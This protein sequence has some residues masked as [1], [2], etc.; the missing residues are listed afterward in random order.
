MHKVLHALEAEFHRTCT[1]ATQTITMTSSG[2][3]T[4]LAP[5]RPECC[6][7][8]TE[9]IFVTLLD[10]SLSNVM[11]RSSDRNLAFVRR[12]RPMVWFISLG[13]GFAP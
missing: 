13:D 10:A 7:N 4:T 9:S 3:I 1:C 5:P 12:L 8:V 6:L 2:R 11:E